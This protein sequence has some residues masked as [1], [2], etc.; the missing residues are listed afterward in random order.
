MKRGMHAYILLAGLCW[1]PRL[2]AAVNCSGLPTSFTGNEFPNGN[3]FSN[4][5]NGALG[6]CY[7]IPLTFGNGNNGQ[8]G[9]L[10]AVYWRIYYKINPKYQLILV[11]EY[12]NA[13]YF[14]VTAYDDHSAI[15]Q[16]ILDADIVPLTSQNV[17]PYSPGVA[18]VPGQK[19]VVPIGFEGTPGAIETGCEMN[20]YNVNVNALD[21]TIRHAG[22]NWNTDPTVFQKAPNIPVHQV[23]TPSHSVPNTAGEILIRAYLNITTANAQTAPHLIVRDVAS[24]CAYPSAYILGLPSNELVVTTNQTTGQSWQ[25]STQADGHRLYDNSVL[26]P[27]CYG[28]GSSYPPAP[29]SAV[30]LSWSRGVEYVPGTNPSAS[31][32]SASVPAGIPATLQAANEVMRIRLRIPVVPPTPCTDGCSRSGNEQLRYMSLSFQNPNGVTLASLAD[33]SF[34]QDPNGYAT[35]I[36]GTGAAIPSYITPANGYTFLDLTKLTGYQ[37]LQSLYIRNL[38]STG[39]FACSGQVVPFNTTVYTPPPLGGLMGDYL[40]VVDYPVAGTLPQVASA[41]VGPNACDVFPNGR[42][43]ADPY[44]GVVSSSPIAISSVPPQATG[45]SAIAVQ[46]LPPITLNGGG[47]GLLPQGLPY[48][49]NTNY[50]KI[51]DVTQNWSA[52]YTGNPCTVSIS[53]WASNEIELV[54]NV[55]QNGQC[56]LAAGDQINIQLWNPQTLA[57]PATATVT[58]AP[59]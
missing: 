50:L 56:P 6:S 48:T 43:A 16:S 46:A 52:G 11:G 24:G 12:P 44:C 33:D 21:A 2:A 53:N 29:T 9:D 41:L 7:L 8:G 23:D 32:V 5:V 22:M 28:P 57:G 58:V 17:N 45:L 19:Y 40:P 35:L 39:N 59:N 55:N 31:Y 10:N 36:V 38:A 15:S 37:N 14:S 27:Y 4:F 47:F 26:V 3:F 54:A 1:F 34:T 51:T 42:P 49:G 25:N 20:G 30:E 18:F 13:R